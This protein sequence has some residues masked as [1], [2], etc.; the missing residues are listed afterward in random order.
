MREDKDW[1][2]RIKNK[3]GEQCEKIIQ[4]HSMGNDFINK[5]EQLCTDEH[6]TKASNLTLKPHVAHSY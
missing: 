6:T 1:I 3:A 4:Y 5:L 2:F